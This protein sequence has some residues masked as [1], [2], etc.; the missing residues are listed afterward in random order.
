[1]K[2]RNIVWLACVA[3]LPALILS[4]SVGANLAGGNLG[5]TVILLSITLFV[6]MVGLL[7]KDRVMGGSDE[8]VQE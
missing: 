4:T 8:N 7:M 6:S 2:H 1:M 3:R 5:A